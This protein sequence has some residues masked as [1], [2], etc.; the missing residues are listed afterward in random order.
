MGYNRRN[1][2][3][4]EEPVEQ[5]RTSKRFTKNDGG[6]VCRHCGKAVEPLGYSSRNHCPFCLWS[7]H[8]DVN[9][10]DRASDCGGPMEPVKAEPDPKRGYIITHRCTKCGA[11]RRNKSAHEAKVQPDDL[12]KLIALTVGRHE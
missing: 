11:L 5:E 3:K 10:G 7:L 1:E 9:P 12:R 6:F 4:G 8:L 2:G